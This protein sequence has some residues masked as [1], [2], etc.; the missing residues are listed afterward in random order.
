MSIHV[1]FYYSVCINQIL[2]LHTWSSHI[3]SAITILHI[4]WISTIEITLQKW[5]NFKSFWR[6][7]TGL[8]PVYFSSPTQWEIY[9]VAYYLHWYNLFN[10]SEKYENRQNS[11]F[12]RLGKWGSEIKDFTLAHMIRTGRTRVLQRW[13]LLILKP[14]LFSNFPNPFSY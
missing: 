4:T 10:S 12:Y 1:F 9:L 5:L 13:C 6:H 2:G 11:S 3:I 7:F 8:D 14:R